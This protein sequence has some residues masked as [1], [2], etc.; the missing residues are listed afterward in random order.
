V[1]FKAP[2]SGGNTQGTFLSIDPKQFFNLNNSSSST[3]KQRNSGELPSLNRIASPAKGFWSGFKQM[4]TT[5]G[6][7]QEQLSIFQ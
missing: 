4:R 6:V 5:S 7:S 3:N 1:S 2:E